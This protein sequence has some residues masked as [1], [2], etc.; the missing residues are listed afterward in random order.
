MSDDWLDEYDYEDIE[1]DFEELADLLDDGE[2]EEAINLFDGD[3]LADGPVNEQTVA[4]FMEGYEDGQRDGE[5]LL[6]Q[7]DAF[8]E[9]V[10]EIEGYED[11][12]QTGFQQAFGGGMEGD[13][14][15]ED[16]D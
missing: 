16:A 13:S 8:Q 15:D 14:E 1:G 10:A 7:D 9:S 12:Y 5:Y 2:V 3:F 6:S 4:A 11:G